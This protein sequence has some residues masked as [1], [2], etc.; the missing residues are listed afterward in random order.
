MHK[1]VDW[2]K[3][4]KNTFLGAPWMRTAM[5][6]GSKNLMSYRIPV[7]VH[8]RD[9]C[10]VLWMRGRLARE[11]YPESGPVTVNPRH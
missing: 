2:T 10:A 4:P 9:A 5:R 7:L 1:G 8:G 3:P 11:P 6:T